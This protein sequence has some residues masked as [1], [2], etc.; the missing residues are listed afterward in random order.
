ML[1]FRFGQRQKQ[2]R[3]HKEN[4]DRIVE[5]RASG[6]H[7]NDRL[8][9]FADAADHD[10][11]MPEGDE[12]GL[13][14]GAWDE[15]G[16]RHYLR[17]PSD[18]SLFVCGAAGSFKSWSLTSVNAISTAL[19]GEAQ[20][21]L[22]VK[23]ELF[24]ACHRGLEQ[25]HGKASIRIAPFESGGFRVNLLSDLVRL[26]ERGDLSKDDCL[27]A[28]ETFVPQEK[29]E[30]T[31]GWIGDE[32]VRMFSPIMGWM[33]YEKF[34]RNRCHVGEI[35][36]LSA[37]PITAFLK[38]MELIAESDGLDGWFAE[39]AKVTLSKY[40]PNSKGEFAEDTLRQFGYA[41][42][43]AKNA[44]APYSKGGKLRGFVS[45]DSTEA[46]DDVW[47]PGQLKVNPQAAFL[48]IP[49]RYTRSH[50]DFVSALIDYAIRSIRDTNGTVRTN[51]ILDEI[52]NIGRV[53]SVPE[54]LQLLRGYGIRFICAVQDRLS[55]KKYEKVGGS[56][57]FESQSIQLVWTV[58]PQHAREIEQRAGYH[59]EVAP[60]YGTSTGMQG[61]SG[62]W[63]GSEFKKPNLSV[64]EIGMVGKGQAIFIAP[65][66]PVGVLQRPIYSDIP[67]VAPFIQDIRDDP[68]YGTLMHG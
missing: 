44:F 55:L 67:W 39:E 15:G 41:M 68:S 21:V 61:D 49:A 46:A 8:L 17:W 47:E 5:N 58:G 66:L 52:G 28:I 10:L 26:A 16:Q 7:A 29:R 53:M 36:D 37:K 59:T 32:T 24:A 31:N 12:G 35:A 33:A 9:D 34:M 30:G 23:G 25:I 54:G 11:V 64:A 19:A 27:A 43:V 42:S 56:Q 50:G 20:L 14:L 45:V 62:D 40:A 3:L 2:R 51:F 13:Y 63:K 48:V 22:D 1:L 4:M 18:E 60:S 57:L 65:G 6:R 38:V